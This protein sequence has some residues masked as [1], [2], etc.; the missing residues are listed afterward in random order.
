MMYSLLEYSVAI[1]PIIVFLFSMW[2]LD[3]FQLIGF[4]EILLTIFYGF[5]IAGVAVLFHNQLVQ[6]F[7]L[8][9][10][11]HLIHQASILTMI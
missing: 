1:L 2:M 5:L 3:S 6:V 10:I 11:D 9:K 4:K 7:E 8:D